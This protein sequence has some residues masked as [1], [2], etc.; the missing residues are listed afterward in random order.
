MPASTGR[1]PTS[2][3]SLGGRVFGAF[4]IINKLKSVKSNDQLTVHT[5]EVSR[6]K[7]LIRQESLV[8]GQVDIRGAASRSKQ[9]QRALGGQSGLVL[10]EQK[11]KNNFVEYKIESSYSWNLCIHQNRGGGEL[12]WVQ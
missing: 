9:S 1:A 6:S 4:Q 10:F 5:N 12:K 11:M 8:A 2:P 7:Q 3:F